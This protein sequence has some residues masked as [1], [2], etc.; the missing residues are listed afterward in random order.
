MKKNL[1]EALL[2][3]MAAAAVLT[4]APA[5]ADVNP[6]LHWNDVATKVS[7]EVKTDP[8]TESRVF[9]IM[10]IAVHDALNAI[11]PRYE[12][13][14][15]ALRPA[16]GAS[17]DAA[18]AQASHDVLVALLP[19]C[20]AAYEAAFKE[21]MA[22]IPDGSAK[23]RGI[24]TGREAAARTLA[25]RSGD[26]AERQV[27]YT[28]GD[29]PGAY[30]PTPPDFTPAFCVQW[31]G[32]KPFALESSDQYRPVPPPAVGGDRARFDL[33]E[34]DM[35]GVKDGSARSEE[36]SEIARFWYENSTA[37]WNRIARVV[38]SDKELDALDSARLMALVNIA[39]ADGF[40]A[41]FE[42]KYHYKYWRPATAL[43]ETGSPEWLS[44]LWT[45]PVP[46]YPSTHTVLGAS[47]AAVLARFF[48]CDYVTFSST[49]GG[50]YPGITREFWSFTQ[51]ARENGASR[52]FAGLHF[53]SAVEAGYAQGNA[54]GTWAFDHVLKPLKAAAAVTLGGAA[55]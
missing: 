3:A 36:Q 26:G 51:A 41:G 10:H 25:A 49:S 54:V 40:I 5:L 48:G 24:D 15:P 6:V 47:A 14:G 12:G 13:Y 55:R 45:P 33:E 16:A 28:P 11:E 50:E 4:A 30:R 38:A 17:V 23:S 53:T 22:A 21:A 34:V 8:L 19:N 35:M 2:P 29:K 20:A 39:M 31:G 46:D 32:I 27:D 18:V 43:R 42:A 1:L 9:A 52:V 44:Y 7:A 37:G